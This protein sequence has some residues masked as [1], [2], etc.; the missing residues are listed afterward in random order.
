MLSLEQY[1]YYKRQLSLSEVGL[2]GQ[3]KLKNA[4]VLIIGMGGL[5]CPV[6]LYLSAAGI[7]ILGLSDHDCVDI[8]NL[9]R[10][11]LYST[12]EVGKPKVACAQRKL[13]AL[14]PDI[15]INVHHEGLTVDNATTQINNYD[16]V[17]DCSDNFP[18]RYLISDTCVALKRPNVSGSVLRFEGQLGMFCGA[19]YPC[20]RCLYP[21]PPSGELIPNC[22]DAGVMGILP[23]IIGSLQAN[24]VIKLILG[25]KTHSPNELICF[26]AIN[27]TLD[28]FK[29]FKKPDC[30]VCGNSAKQPNKQ[31]YRR[32]I[33]DDDYVIKK[34]NVNLLKTMMLEKHDF[35]LLDVRSEAEQHICQIPGSYLI[36]LHQ[37]EERLAEVPQ[38]KNTPVVVYCHHGK[39]SKEAAKI[40]LQHGFTNA[41]FLQGGIDA[42]AICIDD[43]ISTY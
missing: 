13:Q 29:I 16:I 11:V 36:P 37:L 4:R 32:N 9:H 14:N 23:G 17:V 12:D 39:R 25:L 27:T 26:N 7:G 1:E 33:R 6:S 21:T 20:L 35:F 10:Q 18:T 40:L 19:H 24:E 28:K 22:A 8:S 41:K 31:D 43:K 34:I 15:E 30:P 2:S 38:S 42:W 5:G 3:T